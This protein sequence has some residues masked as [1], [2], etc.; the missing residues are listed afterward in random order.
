MCWKRPPLFL[1]QA[2]AS[3]GLLLPHRPGSLPALLGPRQG[4][5]VVYGKDGR[6]HFAAAWA[7]SPAPF[8]WGSSVSGREW[9]SNAWRALRIFRGQIVSWGLLA[10]GLV[11]G[12]GDFTGRCGENAI[13]TSTLTKTRIA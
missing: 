13:P 5:A 12:L 3:V 2:A 7:M 6:N 10:F 11:Y 8:C 1:S 9:R 4:Q